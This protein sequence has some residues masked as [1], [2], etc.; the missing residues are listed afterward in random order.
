MTELEAAQARELEPALSDAVGAALHT[1]VDRYVQP[2]VADRRPRR[3]TLR[4]RGVAIREGAPVTALARG[5]SA[6]RGAGG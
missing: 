5:A 1:T 4:A 6:R 2:A 3:G